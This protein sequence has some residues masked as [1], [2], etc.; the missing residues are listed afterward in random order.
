MT[1]HEARSVDGE[2]IPYVQVGPAKETG[3]AP[4]HMTGY[5]G[6]RLV[7]LPYYRRPSASCGWS[8][9]APR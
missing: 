1:R 5:G 9:A 2:R 6:F 7:I 3:D 8:A 4:V